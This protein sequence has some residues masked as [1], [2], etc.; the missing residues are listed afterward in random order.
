MS[1]GRK[2]SLN[3]VTEMLFKSTTARVRCVLCSQIAFAVS[4]ISMG[5]L[6]IIG[7][8]ATFR[9]PY[10][11]C[12]VLNVYYS[13][14]WLCLTLGIVQVLLGSVVATFLYFQPRCAKQGNLVLI[15]PEGNPLGEITESSGH[16]LPRRYWTLHL[17]S[18]HTNSHGR[19]H[20]RL[21]SCCCCNSDNQSMLSDI[22]VW[23]RSIAIIFLLIVAAHIA[24]IS[25]TAS[26]ISQARNPGSGLITEVENIFIEAKPYFLQPTL[27]M[28][29]SLAA[30]CWH[31][32]ESNRHCCG[33][34]GADDWL[35]DYPANETRLFQNQLHILLERCS[36]FDEEKGI[37]EGQIFQLPS[38]TT[39]SVLVYSRGCS[40]VIYTDIMYDLEVFRVL[41]PISLTVVVVAC[42]A[43]VIVTLI[44]ANAEFGDE[45]MATRSIS[46]II[47][48]S[49]P[50]SIY[51]GSGSI[52]GLTLDRRVN[53]STPNRLSNVAGPALHT[54]SAYGPMK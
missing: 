47:V 48:P 5:L 53:V 32:M 2:P 45:E 51:A 44:V 21:C 3:I 10:W 12:P 26:F 30:K 37:C 18:N 22:T 8:A 13:V 46:T 14:S 50:S 4:L 1:S 11:S 35:S 34:L 17:S 36:C 41:V 43:C 52:P 6:L 38:N 23:F 19:C 9:N 39:K 40:G 29:S 16:N 49:Q 24:A 7:S 54:L 15:G 25:L 20:W 27:P 31:P 33:S 28:S 42:L